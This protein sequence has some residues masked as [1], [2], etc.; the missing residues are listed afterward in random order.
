MKKQTINLVLLLI[1]FACS[2]AGAQASEAPSDVKAQLQEAYGKL[3]LYFEA[4]RGQTNKQVKF[5]NRGRGYSL[6]LTPTEAVLALSPRPTEGEGQGEGAVLRM[7]FVGA[8]PKTRVEGLEKLPGVVNYFIG[9]DPK[10]WRTKIPTYAKVRHKNVYPGVD[11]VYYGNQRQLEYDFIVRPGADPNLIK[12]AFQGAEDVRIDDQGDLILQVGE[13]EVRLLKPNVYQEIKGK[14]QIIAARY[15]LQTNHDDE[16]ITNNVERNL[17]A[18]QVGIQVAAYDASQSLII[19]PVLFYSTYLGGSD[20]DN[21]V[22]IAVDAAGN[23]YVTGGTGSADFPTTVGAF[24]T[25]FSSGDAFVTKLNPTG[26][27]LLYST[28]LG[29]SGGDGG[30]GIALD[31]AGN[32]YV[33]G[34][35]LSTDFPTTP[36]AFQ[37]A[38][39]GGGD[40]FVT[41]LNPTG[42]GL[43]YSTYLGGSG[44]DEC[45]LTCIALDAAGNAY[46]TG[47][48]DSTNFPTTVGAFQTAYGGGPFDAFVTELA[49]TGSGL[50][51]STYLGGS[52]DDEAFGG[53]AVGAAGNAYVTGLTSSTDFPTTPGAFQTVFGGGLYDVF[54]TQ[55]NPLGSGLVSSTYLGGS[56]D[57]E[58]FGIALDAAGNAYVTGYTD[59]TNFPATVGAFQTA[60]GGGGD[61]FVTKLN[62][63]G[64]G[65][66]YFTYLGGSDF[67]QAYEIA[68]DAAGNAYVTGFTNSTDF[69]TTPGAFQTALAGNFDAFITKVNPSGSGLVYSTYLG[70]SG[71][72]IAFGIVL[73][74]LPNPNAYVTGLTNSTDFPTTPG[75]FQPAFAGGFADGFVAQITEAEVPPG[76][77]TARVTGGGTID[78]VGGI[79]TFHFIV[80]RQTD[81]TL[82]GRLQYFNHASGAKVRSETYTSL[83][84]VL[85]TATFDG[86]CTINGTP[87]TFTV[88]VT[89]NGEPGTTDTFTI[90]V[91]GGPTEGGVLRSGNILI[92]Q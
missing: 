70:G 67:E 39:G 92:T 61:A 36:G 30:G 51:Y 64:T 83:T 23:T 41:K 29:G 48:T 11:L 38:Y 15:I 17:V 27:G 25:T 63:L 26:S 31:A 76:P 62:P 80:Q 20:F 50:V 53:I 75:A 85:N 57:D 69:P 58:G 37:T 18:V 77:F 45:S 43:L 91:D 86:T 7:S 22:G 74:T 1:A 78:V 14:K 47:F 68:V 4:N 3:P 79:G 46:L 28:Y 49:P 16:R 71:D 40:A 81:G 60:N 82:S 12:L 10:K 8:Y 44:F 84:I 65:L 34:S 54:V 72:E 87:C 32:A 9:N 35:T 24:Q 21:S 56:G 5:L 2:A 55:M 52:G 89:D 19:D 90:S 59:S 42:S 13:G 66:A 33:T 6:F 88:N 73:D